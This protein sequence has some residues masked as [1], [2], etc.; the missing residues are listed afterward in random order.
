MPATIYYDGDC[1]FC[2]R[3][4]RYVR[5]RDAVGGVH[6]ID[7]RG[8]EKE[9]ER[10][11]T[12]GWNLDQGMVVE[13]EGH[14]Y[15]GSDAVHMLALLSSASDRF[16]RFNRALLSSRIGARML[17]PL[18]RMGR[19][20]TLLALDRAP[21]E[22]DTEAQRA[23]RTLFC[24]A[25][26][27]FAYLHV[28]VYAF[29]YG[30]EMHTTT[31]AIAPLGIALFW[32]PLSRRIFLALLVMM[33]VDAWRQLPSLSN[34][35]F[36]K[37]AFIHS[38]A[39]SGA[40]HAIRGG[41]W[42]DFLSDASPVGRFA[43]VCMYIFGV[44]HKLN[45]GFLDPAVSCAVVLWRG[46]PGF[47]SWIDFPA[48]HQAT[49]YGTLVIESAILTC[50][51]LPRTRHWGIVLGIGF[52]AL[53]AM[54]DYAIYAPFSTLTIALH[55]LFL[56]PGSAQRVIAST[57]W[58]RAQAWLRNP[59][60]IAAFFTWLCV[61]VLLGWN[62]SYGALGVLWLPVVG[63]LC[64][65]IWRHGKPVGSKAGCMLLWSP[66]WWLNALSVL[67]LL[68]CFS[69]YLGS[70]TAQSMNMFANLRL[71]G[72]LS[73]HLVFRNPPGPFGYLSDIVEITNGGHSPYLR[74]IK[75]QGLRVTYYDLLDKLER[76]PQLNV[77]YRRHG[78]AYQE[79]SA[80]TLAHDIAEKLHPRWVRGWF[81]FNP[82]DLTTPKPC[83][84]NR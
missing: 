73:N 56:P 48:F 30:A 41:H 63:F 45:T 58:Q 28:V 36:L 38:L 13:F 11:A 53:L 78:R 72:D 3:Y 29:Q 68:G 64:Y 22:A 9:R 16:N 82:V 43:L 57:T 46:M 39:L 33:L 74:Y 52:H 1:P 37:N 4:V 35:T 70:K 7:L 21:I 54:S 42:R 14:T 55:L 25:W 83:A 34:H 79:Q 67:F 81:H 19:G 60:G 15:G 2:S 32:F 20:V 80:A 40:W 12:D 24:M 27:L 47:L 61:L 18:L 51:L 44:F 76:D 23:F 77:S 65:A 71:E 59:A 8:N 84:L 49:I 66:L 50:L 31:W 75:H 26:G 6:L 17:Y 5:L 62:R 10:L 69:P